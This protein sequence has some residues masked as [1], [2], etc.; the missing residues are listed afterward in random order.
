MPL[1]KVNE[2]LRHATEN[3][4]GVAAVNVFNYETI[5]WVAEAANRERIPV[6]SRLRQVHRLK[7]CGGY[8]QRFCRKIFSAHRRTSGSFRRL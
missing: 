6:L 1:V 3:G 4:Y 5:K 7:T 2:L 8:R